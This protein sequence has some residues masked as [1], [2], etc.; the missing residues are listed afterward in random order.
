MLSS[1]GNTANVITTLTRKCAFSL[2]QKIPLFKHLKCNRSVGLPNLLVVNFIY[3]FV[4]PAAV[5][6][7]NKIYGREIWTR[8][9]KNHRKNLQTK[10]CQRLPANHWKVGE[11]PG[12]IL[13]QKESILL[14]L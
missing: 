6:T 8:T 5:D 12:Q 9:K 1:K 13:P 11:R 3:D 7:L 10:E 14:K 2:E 4:R